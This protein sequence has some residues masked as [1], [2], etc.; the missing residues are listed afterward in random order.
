MVRVVLEDKPEGSG[1]KKPA[2]IKRWMVFRA[3]VV[4]GMLI[5]A[6][7]GLWRKEPSYN[8]KTL[9][10]WVDELEWVS[11]KLDTEEKRAK[12][13]T[14]ASAIREMGPAV[15][16]ILLSRLRPERSRWERLRE[17]WS[18]VLRS[19]YEM[20]RESNARIFAAVEALGK[21]AKGS[22]PRMMELLESG[23]VPGIAIVLSE[24]F[25]MEALPY[26]GK[27][28]TNSLPRVRAASATGIRMLGENG[29]EAV[30]MM[31]RALQDPD[32]EVRLQATVGLRMLRAD[33]VQ[34]VPA[35]V[36]ALNDFDSRV[37]EEAA[38]GLGKYGGEAKE[39]VHR[40]RTLA[41][42]PNQLGVYAKESLQLIEATESKA[43]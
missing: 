33:A 17:I 22:I 8:R 40:L 23:E 9:T 11:A 27:G 21:E 6:G 25:G 28:M 14:A 10:A 41:A 12:H 16:P 13:E 20:P 34:A 37:Q 5:L 36:T 39:A 30:P 1:M 3:T 35:L 18:N 2:P 19:D 15:A 38:R 31:L 7:Y 29:K 32:A 26:L 42:T 43:E 24:T 4:C